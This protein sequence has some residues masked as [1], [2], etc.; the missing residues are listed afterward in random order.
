MLQVSLPHGSLEKSEGSQK[1]AEWALTS[2]RW[3]VVRDGCELKA[4]EIAREIQQ[5]MPR[6]G[7]TSEMHFTHIKEGKMTDY[8]WKLQ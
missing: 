4:S 1:D 7:K 2:E 5:K 8:N 6:L 3:Q